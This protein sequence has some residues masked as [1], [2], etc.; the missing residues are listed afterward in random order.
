MK[1]KKALL[2]IIPALI[3]AS[4]EDEKNEPPPVNEEELITSVY[5]D[6]VDTASGDTV[7]FSFVDLDGDGGNAPVITNGTLKANTGYDVEISFLNESEIPAEDITIEVIDE[8]DEHQVFYLIDNSLNLTMDYSTSARNTDVD[9]RPI[10]VEAIANTMGAS[11]GNL[12]IV[13][14]HEPNKAA[15]G[16]SDG[17]ITNAGGETDIE[18]NFSAV[19]Q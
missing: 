1:I 4:C 5:V 17:D 14:R 12:Q 9:G 8:G 18:V 3:L 11:N 15:T 16:V 13:L 19:I 6:F 7:S 2:L 10:G